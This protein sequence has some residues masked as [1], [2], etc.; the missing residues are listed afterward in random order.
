MDTKYDFL[1][2]E[3]TDKL[4]IAI[5]LL[6][7][8]QVI[9]PKLSLREVYDKYLH[10]EVLDADNPVIWEHLAA[11][12]VLDVFQFN[13]G[14]GLAIAKK[15]T[16]QNVIE[17]LAASAMMRLMS[18]K[19][20]ESQQDRYARIKRDGI[21]VFDKEM[22]D[23]GLPE[24][25]IALMHKHC[26]EYYG[27]CAIQEQMMLILMEVA[28]FTLGEANSARKVVAKKQM[29]KIPQLKELVY[30]KMGNENLANYI[31]TTAV[32]PQLGY[33]F[34]R[35]HS[36]PYSFVGVQ[37]IF[38]ATAFNPIYW[39]TACLIVN[40]GSADE[41]AGGS[42]DYTKIAKAMGE[43]RSK[44]IEVSLIDIN[45]STYTFKPDVVNNRI[46]FGFK[47]MSNIGDDL[48]A[49]II[50]NR[51]YVSMLDFYNRVS[52][53]KQAMIMLIKGGA[54]DQF[55][56][57]HE[58]MV[59][60]IW[61]TCDKKS[62][63]TLQNMPGLITRNLLPQDEEY[64]GPRR[65]YEFNRYLKAEC[66]SRDK[67]FF[68]LDDRA[69]DFLSEFG[70]D[71]LITA[72]NNSM[73]LNIKQWDKV[74]QG[75]MDV[76]RDWINSNKEKILDELNT[77]IFMEDWKK[78]AKRPTLSAWEMEA[79]CFYYHE[80]E[81]KNVNTS[82]YGIVD[83]Y[84]L[85]EE[86]VVEKIYKRGDA[87]IP[88]YRLYKI[89]GTCIAKNK[90]K[91]IAYVLTNGGVVPVKFSREYFSMFDR[92]ISERNADGTK[93]IKEKS[94]FNRGEMIMV[95]G[96]RRGDDFVAKKYAAS[97][98]HQLYHIDAIS[99]NGDLMIRHERYQG[100]QEEDEEN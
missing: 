31:W 75:W 39:N 16:P 54:F 100:E 86:P 59:E 34:S 43:I 17:M 7:A 53:K 89:C 65:I 37:T 76:F 98:S 51:P 91:G 28:G 61:T 29:D 1:V 57:R 14:S 81:L 72:N 79:L 64:K 77:S 20:V 92:Q 6:Q 94:W 5:E 38:L 85:A 97:P 70:Y 22:K 15:V 12:D 71:N 3:V 35:N 90:N 25:I 50:E 47:A 68:A 46:L 84:K 27:C 69:I 88:I 8:D 24:N 56:S 11:G 18:E 41:E 74:Y 21:Q 93:T 45:N 73:L 96:M 66:K 60:F 33:A 48:I 99:A 10:P 63:L 36:L 80:H 40:S 52:P 82:K 2:T 87:N 67:A 95:Q 30:S 13:E 58:T 32:A 26:D 23:A 19:G 4:I 78:Y 44:G 42:T 55:K 49:Q 83:F 9:D 62:R